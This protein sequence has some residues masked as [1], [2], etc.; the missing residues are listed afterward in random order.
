MSIDWKRYDTQG[1]WD[2]LV[3]A[4]GRARPGASKLLTA[5]AKLDDEEL[6]GLQA[7]A[8]RAIAS[9]GITFT[10]YTGEGSGSID[11]EWPFD[12][13]PRV[14]AKREWDRICHGLEQRVRALNAFIDDVYHN[15]RCLRDGVVPSQF[16]LESKDYRR[17]CRGISPAHGVWSHI[18]GSDLVRDADGTVYVLEDN[19][20]VPSGVSY[21]I[22]NREVLKRTYPELFKNR[23]SIPWTPTRTNS[24]A[25]WRA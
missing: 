12:V 10:V 1:A 11:R 8:E 18:C 3:R 23:R 22:E 25:R 13:I 14:I 15:Q 7:N 20:R 5:L 24:P 6:T 16:V 21:M 17:Q 19:L 4:N 9:M 2:E